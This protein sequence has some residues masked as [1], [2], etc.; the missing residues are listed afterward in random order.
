MQKKIIEN[1]LFENSLALV[2][3]NIEREKEISGFRLNVWCS[4]LSHMYL[5]C[6]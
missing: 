3:F 2:S 5:G 4:G 6:I 1:F